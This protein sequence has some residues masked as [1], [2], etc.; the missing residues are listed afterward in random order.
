VRR[1]VDIGAPAGAVMAV[2]TDVG[3]YPAW[4]RE[5]SRVE[6]HESDSEGRPTVATTFIK[7][8]GRAGSY[9]VR[10]DY[11]TP[12]EMT[13]RL[14]RADMMSRHEARFVVTASG[15]GCRLEVTIDLEL[16]WAIPS[17]LLTSLVHKGITAMLGSVKRQVETAG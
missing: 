16:K 3:N 15:A 12:L 4:Q 10:Y 1:S 5:V 7:A 11:P 17:V 14:V 8:V 9:T 13:Y 6:V 2:L